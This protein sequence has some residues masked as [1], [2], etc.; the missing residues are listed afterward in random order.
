MNV[1]LELFSI[2]NMVADADR[3]RDKDCGVR[4]PKTNLTLAKTMKVDLASI[5]IAVSKL[6]LMYGEVRREEAISDYWGRSK[7]GREMEMV[8]EVVIY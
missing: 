5:A 6:R 3:L 4:T 8:V 1:R 7:G 2:G